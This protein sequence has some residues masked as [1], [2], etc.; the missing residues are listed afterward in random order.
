M[1]ARW[2]RS[3]PPDLKTSAGAMDHARLDRLRREE[4]LEIL[5]RRAVVIGRQQA[6]L[7]DRETGGSSKAQGG[8]ATG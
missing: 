7:A 5:A 4:L 3:A 1:T 8:E 2:N 6:E